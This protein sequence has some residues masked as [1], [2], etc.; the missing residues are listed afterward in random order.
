MKAILKK[1]VTITVTLVAIAVALSGCCMFGLHKD[2]CCKQKSCGMNT[3][4]GVSVGTDGVSAS[5]GANAGR[6]GVSSTVSAG[7]M[8]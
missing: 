2:C 8:R 7:T 4:M 1:S 3:S 6:H 5:G